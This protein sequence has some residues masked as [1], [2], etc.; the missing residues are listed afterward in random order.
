MQHAYRPEADKVSEALKADLFAPQGALCSTGCHRAL[1]WYEW[2]TQVAGAFF[3]LLRHLERTLARAVA[4]ELTEHFGRGNWWDD[5]RI[6]L[7]Y[8]ARQKIDD[9]VYDRS[10]N[11]RNL[12][13]EDVQRELTMGFWVALLGRGN[14]YETR[15]WRPA[16]RHAFPGYRGTR[17]DVHRTLDYLRTFRNRVAHLEPIGSRDLEADRRSIYRVL[18]Y[19]SADVAQWAIKADRVEGIIVARPQQCTPRVP[20]QRDGCSK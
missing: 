16:L 9:L 12:T 14:D 11:R 17:A 13:T 15:L 20:H 1:H 5:P 3:E 10:G 4:R 18:G 19:L 8:V 2:E 6:R 7:H